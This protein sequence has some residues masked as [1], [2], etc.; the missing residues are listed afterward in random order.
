MK[1]LE[2]EIK[3]VN[4]MH[5]MITRFEH[6]ITNDYFILSGIF[7]KIPDLQIKGL[8]IIK[9]KDLPENLK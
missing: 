4:L 5:G 8:L 9:G 2:L 1:E 6:T 7:G 3:A